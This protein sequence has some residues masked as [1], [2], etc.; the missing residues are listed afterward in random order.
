MDTRADGG[1]V[2]LFEHQ[3]KR[4][5]IHKSAHVAATAVVC[6]D[7]TVGADSY[8]AF[9]AVLVA[10]GGSV[11]IGSQCVVMENAVIRGTRRY[12][13]QVG[14][15]V[16]VGPRVYLSGCTIEDDVFLAT[17]V[18]VFNG[19]R[20]GARSEVRINGVVHLKTILPE[21]SVVPI[22]WVAVGDPVAILPPGRHDEIWAVQ[23]SLD[24]PREIFGLERAPAGQSIMPELT[25]RYARFLKRHKDDR[26]LD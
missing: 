23:E 21:D 13:A 11:V 18:T 14:S 6:G 16:L 19:A 8:V 25:R 26:L 24:F 15:N 22:G 4:P 10:E 17:G 9:G 20:I 12:H 3:G 1:L 7:V 2:V 5:D